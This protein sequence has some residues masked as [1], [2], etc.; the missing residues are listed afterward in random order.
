[1]AAGGGGGGGAAPAGGGRGGRGSQAAAHT[2]KPPNLKFKRYFLNIVMSN[3][4]RDLPFSC[5]HPLKS[6]DD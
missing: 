6:A 4:V 2:P 3:V 5:N 1:V